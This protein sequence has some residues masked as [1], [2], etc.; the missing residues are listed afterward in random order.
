MIDDFSKEP[1]TGDDIAK[2]RQMKREWEAFRDNELEPLK[3]VAW[4]I[5][6]WRFLAFLVVVG[7]AGTFK[8]VLE[9]A[10]VWI[11]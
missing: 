3:K 9:T 5:R 6:N 4:A 10:R 8:S 1:L 7:A 2:F 11:Q